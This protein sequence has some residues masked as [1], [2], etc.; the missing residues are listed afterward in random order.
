MLNFHSNQLFYLIS[1][2]SY[3]RK[4]II[5]SS[6]PYVRDVILP[7]IREQNKSETEI[8]LSVEESIDRYLFILFKFLTFGGN[9]V[10]FL[11]K[12]RFLD[13]LDPYGKMSLKLENV[14]FS[15]KLPSSSE[16][17]ILIYDRLRPE[18]MERKWKKLIK[19]NFDISSPK[20][21]HHN[22]ILMPYSMHP[23]VYV[24]GQ[25]E[26]LYHFR[27]NSRKARIF[28]AGNI[29]PQLYK[30]FKNRY[31]RERF[32]KLLRP[33]VIQ[34]LISKLE[35]EVLLVKD[36]EQMRLV[37]AGNYPNKCVIVDRSIFSIHQAEWLKVLSKSDFFVCPP[38]VSMPLSHNVIEAMAVGTIPILNYTEWFKPCLE[39]MK[40]CI[41]F[42]DEEN[43]IS[44]VKY[45][46][47]MEQ[48]QINK[49]H[50]NVIEYYEKYLS[51]QSFQQQFIYNSNDTITL[52]INTEQVPYLHKV[53]CDS[54]II[55]QVS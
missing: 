26:Q 50:K 45:V 25:H 38:G 41:E 13:Y 47:S 36:E 12:I 40:N 53:Q 6:V 46:L 44:N 52:F 17:K 37:L 21:E 4:A 16:D 31:L 34:T 55:S 18:L 54:V 8:Y 2:L 24:T 19:V 29:N 1:K 5:P 20:M 22:W 11:N 35:S 39:H 15:K 49:M 42:S 7:D 23:I 14:I 27:D 51:P 43:L 10:T 32:N 33:E 48:A 30:S 3:N 9:T 28:F